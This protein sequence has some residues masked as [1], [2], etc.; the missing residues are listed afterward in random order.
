MIAAAVIL[1]VAEKSPAISLPVWNASRLVCQGVTGLC[2]L[3][4][5]VSPLVGRGSRSDLKE[6]LS[7]VATGVVL[8]A[9]AV[10]PLGLVIVI[11]GLVGVG[12]AVAG[13]SAAYVGSARP[14]R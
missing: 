4:A 3:A 6:T 7:T 14:T 5:I 11:T 1:I 9:A 12:L 13:V 2:G 8:V 10:V